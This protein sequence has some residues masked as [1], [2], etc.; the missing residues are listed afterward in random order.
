MSGP[1]S[2]YKLALTYPFDPRA[3]GVQIP[4][5]YPYPTTTFK[6][7][8]TIT[9]L[10]DSSGTLSGMFIPHPYLSFV[11]MCASATV[12]TSLNRW[13]GGLATTNYYVASPATLADKLANFRIVSTGLEVKNL[14]TQLNCTGRIMMVKTPALQNIPGPGMLNS[15]L[16]NLENRFISNIIAGIEPGGVNNGIPSSI[17][18]LPKS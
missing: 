7:E 13:V 17:L 6:I 12:V 3:V 4:D 18:S 9:M 11:N 8:G 1:L 16:Y 14:L 2:K 10:A 15:P 5:P